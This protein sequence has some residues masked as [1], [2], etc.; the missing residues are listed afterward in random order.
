M[1]ISFRLNDLCARKA[2]FLS[3][4]SIYELTTI[5]GSRLFM[6]AIYA[7]VILL[8]PVVVESTEACKGRPK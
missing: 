2:E 7:N 1:K 6:G 5:M 3:L 4:E 8:F